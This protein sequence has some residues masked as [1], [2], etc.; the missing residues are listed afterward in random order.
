LTSR[1]KTIGIVGGGIL[2]MTLALRLAQ[3][4]FKVTILEASDKLGGLAAPC[5]IGPYTWDRFYHVILMSDSNTLDLLEEL[6]LTDQINW[7]TA[8]TGF[9]TD[10]NL[11]SMSNVFEFLAF[12]PLNLFDKFRLGWTIFYTSRMKSWERLEEILVTQW[13]TRYSGNRTFEKI[14]LPLLKSK[15][16]QNYKIA[17]AAFIWATIN[18]MYAAR[19][20][21]LKQEMF[22]YTAGGYAQ[23]LDRFQ[24]RLDDLGINSLCD[25]AVYKIEN[26]GTRVEVA[27]KTDNDLQFDSAILTMPTTQIP[28]LCPVCTQSENERLSN[29]KYGGVI[30]LALVVKKPLAAYYITN[31][32]DEWVP[33]SAVI[34]MTSLVDNG[35]FDSNRLIYLPLY[36]DQHDPA[37]TKTDEEVENEFL[38]ALEAMYPS[39]NR[40]DVLFI[41]ISRAS[42]VLPITTLNYTAEALP[43]TK[44]SL[45]KVF[46]VNSAQ[47]ANGT[48]NVNEIV[49]LANRKAREIANYLE[50]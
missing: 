14:W 47:I 39:F 12:P 48:M 45:Q 31:I 42:Y 26:N 4:G 8:K 29:V 22:G 37:W 50:A 2:G 13:L 28:P 44:T 23:I 21:G 32:T 25:T 17:N 40:N 20:S 16:G 38:N 10:G 19:R 27:T 11:Y 43:Q 18:R 36:L 30:C 41:E 34:E 15:L 46:V 35:N 6:D 7:R 3:Q 24:S 33:F 49:G 5:K 9:F 1:T